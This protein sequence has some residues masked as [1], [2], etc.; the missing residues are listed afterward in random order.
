METMRIK[1]CETPMGMGK[2]D[3]FTVFAD[4]IKYHQFYRS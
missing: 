3:K 2:A 1:D 4:K